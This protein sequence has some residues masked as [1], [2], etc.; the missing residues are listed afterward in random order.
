MTGFARAEGHDGP[1]SWAWELKSVNAKSLDLRFRLPP[2]P[3]DNP[4]LASLH[5]AL[6]PDDRGELYFV[7]DG[8][9]GHAFSDTLEQH[10][11]N[12]AR[13]RALEQGLRDG[14]APAAGQPAA[15]ITGPVRVAPM[16]PLLQLP[17]PTSP[18]QAPR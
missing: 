17:P 15:P 16:R 9:G 1:L 6:Q 4:G 11:R 10:Q 18:T 7:A 2:T 5:A 12:V 14:T 3:I 13:L 8:T